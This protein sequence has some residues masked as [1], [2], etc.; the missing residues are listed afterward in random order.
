M[1][2]ILTDQ[3]GAPQDGVQ[4][5]LQES[6]RHD[7]VARFQGLLQNVVRPP[8]ATAISGSD[9]AF[10]LG[11]ALAPS[12]PMELWVLATGFSELRIGDLTVH[13]NAFIDLGKVALENGRTVH[14]RVEIAGTGLPAQRHWSRSS[15]AIRSKI[16]ATK[17]STPMRAG[18]SC[19][20]V[21]ANTNGSTFQA[22]A[23]G[24]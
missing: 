11:L 23:V 12:S 1:R 16:S 10:E 6:S 13:A 21:L 5:F 24:G 22:M 14:G 19:A 7:L 18:P 9:G 2:G 17:V 3:A 20:T 15:Q 4:V 8:V